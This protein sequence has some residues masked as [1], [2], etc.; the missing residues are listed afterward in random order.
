MAPPRGRFIV[1]G[2]RKA[3]R[4]L[5]RGN[6]SSSE[7][8]DGV[9]L[10]VV[11]S[12]LRFLSLGGGGGGGISCL[13]IVSLS[14]VGGWSVLVVLCCPH[15]VQCVLVSLL[16]CPHLIMLMSSLW[17]HIQIGSVVLLRP[18]VRHLIKLTLRLDKHIHGLVGM[19]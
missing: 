1:L 14:V 2:M 12:L 3:R 18:H 17:L 9:G 19:W 13:S 10:Y 16:P 5:A 4:A 11:N 8:L 15:F 6:V 7:E